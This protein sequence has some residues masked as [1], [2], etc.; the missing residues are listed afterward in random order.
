MGQELLEFSDSEGMLSKMY[1]CLC[2]EKMRLGR[3]ELVAL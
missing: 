3:E 2:A 1:L